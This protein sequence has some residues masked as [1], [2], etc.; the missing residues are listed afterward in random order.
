LRFETP[1]QATQA[2]SIIKSIPSVIEEQLVRVE[3]FPAQ[4]RLL[5]SGRYVMIQLYGLLIRIIIGA[6]LLLISNLLGP[7]GIALAIAAVISYVGIPSWV[8]F[9]RARRPA[10]GFLRFEGGSIVVRTTLDWV[11]V[12]PNMIHW[13]S[14]E[15]FVL[16]GPAS[17]YELSFPT[18]QSASQAIEMIRTVIP[19][20]QETH[21]ET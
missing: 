12:F 8:V 13:K 18:A 16:K 3:E 20:I 7:V 1:E 21:M 9:V 14:P 10:Q 17:K 19:M 2:A 15:S 4:I 6:F 11:R 5:I